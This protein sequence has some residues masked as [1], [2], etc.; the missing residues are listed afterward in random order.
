[1]VR[2]SRREINIAAFNLTVWVLSVLLSHLHLLGQTRRWGS[3]THTRWRTL[4]ILPSTD[5]FKIGSLAKLQANQGLYT[6]GC[7]H[8]WSRSSGVIN[9]TLTLVHVLIMLFRR[10][11]IELYGV[12]HFGRRI[13]RRGYGTLGW[14]IPNLW[15]RRESTTR[16]MAWFMAYVNPNTCKFWFSQHHILGILVRAIS[17]RRHI[18]PIP[19]HRA[20]L[21]PVH[22]KRTH[23][24]YRSQL[25]LL[26]PL[27][28]QNE[29]WEGQILKKKI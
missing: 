22:P 19:Q 4:D 26:Q 14:T 21:I 6:I 23:A 7:Y 2:F 29:I 25:L 1:M 28:Q 17:Y 10:C 15:A 27:N 13:D 12:P 24:S 5:I 18:L 9:F 16:R 20:L 3:H 8:R 11:K